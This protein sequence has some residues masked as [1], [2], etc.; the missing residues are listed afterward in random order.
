MDNV[1]QNGYLATLASMNIAEPLKDSSVHHHQRPLLETMQYGTQLKTAD[2]IDQ[3]WSILPHW[4]LQQA[5]A[6]WDLY[7]MTRKNLD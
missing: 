4:K 5:L 7:R 6:A 2:P 3:L 1:L